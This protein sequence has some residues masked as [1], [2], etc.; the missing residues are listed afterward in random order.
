MK[1]A[2]N[3]L[4][5]IFANSRERMIDL[6]DIERL[7][8]KVQG[9][10]LLSRYSQRLNLWL[11]RADTK[12]FIAECIRRKKLKYDKASLQALNIDNTDCEQLFTSLILEERDGR[13]LGSVHLAL[14]YAA[15]CSKEL[16]YAIY[17]SFI[18]HNLLDV[19]ETCKERHLLLEDLINNLDDRIGKDNKNC[20][21]NVC[22]WIQKAVLGS[23]IAGW[24]DVDKNTNAHILRLKIMDEI[25]MLSDLGYIKNWD[26][27]KCY[28]ERLGDRYLESL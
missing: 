4:G 5:I 19:R 10:K 15:H 20:I 9:V 28:F 27:L 23:H 13:V 2:V 24:D 11:E 7:G 6:K 25:F 3:D 12:K 26:E 21:M 16:E 1:V 8:M 18:I 14:K 17:D 22:K